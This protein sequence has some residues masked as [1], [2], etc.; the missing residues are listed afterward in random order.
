MRESVKDGGGSDAGR[1]RPV[2]VIGS[3]N[4][5][6]V[7]RCERLP[8]RARRY[9]AGFFH[10]ARR[11]GRQSGGGRGEARRAGQ[12]GRLRRRDQFGATLV[13]RA[14]RRGCRAPMTSL[15]VD[16][17]TGTALITVD[18]DGANTI[19]VI[20]GA[21]VACDTALV[22]RALAVPAAPGS[23]CCNMRFR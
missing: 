3:L 4:M 14:A 8:R 10:R 12:H 21:N 6:L 17:P 20:S 23:C 18:A 16:R 11:Q 9:S 7:A 5:D 15:A 1:E 2:L 19:V 13:G 22:D